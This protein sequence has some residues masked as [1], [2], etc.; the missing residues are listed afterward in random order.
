MLFSQDDDEF[1]RGSDYLLS[2]ALRA[3]ELARTVSLKEISARLTNPPY[4]PDIWPG[5]HYK[6][7]SG[8]VLA[9]EPK[10]IIEIGTGTGLS[11]LCMK[12]YL[13]KESNIITFDVVAWF[14]VPGSV[15]TNADFSDG[16]I[17]QHIADLSDALTF[18]KYS[19]TTA[20]A[21][22]IFID[23]AKDGRCEQLLLQN[24]RTLNFRVRPLILMDDIRLWNMLK[25]WR[26]I[27]APKLDLTSF[28]HWSGTGLVEW[29]GA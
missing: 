20:N 12:R 15:L 5:E 16:Q 14:S 21:D 10:T 19:D 7:L 29:S 25:V 9:L 2:I 26:E 13:P 27:R 4:Y 8:L 17:I 24:L 22:L 1:S 3:I 11:S 6:L 18:A 23:A 28:A